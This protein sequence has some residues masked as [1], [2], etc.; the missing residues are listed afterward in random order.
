MCTQTWHREGYEDLRGGKGRGVWREENG[1][2]ET[3]PRARWNVGE[4]G[5]VVSRVFSISPC[6]ALSGAFVAVEITHF[7]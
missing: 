2:G 4:G 5:E 7:S 6:R 3:I 1:A